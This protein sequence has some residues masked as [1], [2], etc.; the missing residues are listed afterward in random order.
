MDAEQLKVIAEGMGYD[1]RIE[2]QL[3]YIYIYLFLAWNITL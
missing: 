3:V 1:A 2:G